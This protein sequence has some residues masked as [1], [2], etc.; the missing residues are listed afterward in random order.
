VY[1]DWFSQTE[2]RVKGAR[3]AK[4]KGFAT[5]AEAE[6]FAIHGRV[7]A[8]NDPYGPSSSS[9]GHR[10][11]LQ[12]LSQSQ[13]QSQVQ[14]SNASLDR[15]IKTEKSPTPA[16]R[17]I[18]ADG[19]LLDVDDASKFAKYYAVAIG[20]RPG[21]YEDWDGKRGAQE[22]TDGFSG[23]LHQRFNDRK[24]AI[25][26][27]YRAG[28]ARDEILLFKSHFAKCANFESKPAAKF[29]DE[30]K[31]LASSQNWTKPQQIRAAKVD[32]I[33][34]ELISYFLLGGIPTDQVGDNGKI[35]LNPGQTLKV[36][37]SMY[38]MDVR[39]KLTSYLYLCK[40]TRRCANI[41]ES[42]SRPR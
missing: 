24:S 12:P 28:I 15:P 26:F 33:R 23:A 25:S 8:G 27:M 29:K 9:S 7:D 11:P 42:L 3:G 16:K 38:E 2:P 39:H 34:D 22:Q 14:V 31:R 1:T 6:S 10:Q 18:G 17:S 36:R 5:R 32:A 4:Y 41:Q 13:R 40:S 35:K 30:Y 20:R 37:L 21:I 19:K